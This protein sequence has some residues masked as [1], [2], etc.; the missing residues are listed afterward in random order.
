MGFQG[1]HQEFRRTI[2]VSGC[3]PGIQEDNWGYRVHPRNLGG[4]LGFQG[5]YQEFR[6]KIVFPE[7]AFDISDGLS[8]L[9]LARY[10]L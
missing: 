6:R 7:F 2:G 9:E 8:E 10:C 5:V 3:T 4:Q 1:V